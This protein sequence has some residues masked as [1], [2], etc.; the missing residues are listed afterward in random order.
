[1]KT[2]SALELND[3]VLITDLASNS[4]R[5]IHPAL[6]SSIGFLD[7]DKKSQAIVKYSNGQVNRPISKLV[8]IMKAYETIPAKGKCFCPLAEV[9]EQVQEEQEDQEEGPPGPDELDAA[10]SLQ[11]EDQQHPHVLPSLPEG[12]LPQTV[13]ELPVDRMEEVAPPPVEVAETTS[14]RPATV[15][16]GGHDQALLDIS[17]T[18]PAQ[19][20]RNTHTDRP[21]RPERIRKKLSK[22]P[23]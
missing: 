20:M 1:M 5:G 18:V 10:A 3:V 13:E 17:G 6:G 19:G 8:R 14:Q 2:C 4:T 12:P 22:F 15:S 9:D 23:N 11:D 16:R 21:Q 7:P